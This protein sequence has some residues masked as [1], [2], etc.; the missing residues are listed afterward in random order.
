MVLLVLQERLALPTKLKLPVP[1]DQMEFLVLIVQQ[2]EPQLQINHAG[3][4]NVV[5][6]LEQ[7]MINALDKLLERLVFQMAKF[8][9]NKIHVQITLIN[10]HVMVEELMEFVHS[11]QLQQQLN[12]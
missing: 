5:I 11:H 10:Y 6:L 3:P 12:H 4:K 9:S 7:L 2:S 8:V 1:L